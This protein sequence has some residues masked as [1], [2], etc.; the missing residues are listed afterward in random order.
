MQ[1]GA[2]GM[3]SVPGSGNS[4]CKGPEVGRTFVYLWDGKGQVRLN[5]SARQVSSNR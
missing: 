5:Q 4:V 1:V 2:G 3:E